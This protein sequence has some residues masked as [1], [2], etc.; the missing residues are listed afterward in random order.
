M[1]NKWY[2]EWEEQT[3]PRLTVRFEDL[4]FH[5]EEVTKVACECVGGVFTNKPFSYIEGSA[6]ENGM[7]IHD[8]ENAIDLCQSF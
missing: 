4:L 5:G 1:W 6:K 7:P 2:E 3:F 8:G